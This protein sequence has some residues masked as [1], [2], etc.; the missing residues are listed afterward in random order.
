MSLTSM[1]R[2]YSRA[3]SGASCPSLAFCARISSRA[4]A[5]S[6]S[7]N[8]LKARTLFASRQRAV[9]SSRLSSTPKVAV[10]SDIVVKIDDRGDEE[11]AASLAH[12]SME[13]YRSNFGRKMTSRYSSSTSC[14]SNNRLGSF[15]A[16]KSARSGM[17]S[18]FR[19]AETK[20]D[21]ST[22]TIKCC[23]LLAKP[24]TRRQCP[25]RSIHASVASTGIVTSTVLPIRISPHRAT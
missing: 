9:D 22:T 5:A 25:C 24:P 20:V 6:S 13:T 11:K 4:R 18:T 2:S 23:V 8:S 10:S 14:E 12:R 7:C 17:L 1:K 15:T 16:R 19:A 21:A 3:S